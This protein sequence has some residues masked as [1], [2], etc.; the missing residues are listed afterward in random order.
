MQLRP[1]QDAARNAVYTALEQRTDNPCVVL[2]TGAGKTPLMAALVRDTLAWGG[3]IGVVAHV[4]ELLEQTADKL[5]AFDISPM[6]IGI[7]SAGLNSRNTDA[8]CI[9]AG[10]QSVYK[11]ACEFGRFDI[12]LVDEAHL[13]PASGEGMYQTFLADAAVVNPKMRVIG[14][15][16]TPYRLDVGEI[17]APD[18]I[19]NHVCYEASVRD[20]IAQGFLCKLRSK[21]A[22]EASTINVA[23]VA[24]RGGEYVASELEAAADT[25]EAVQGAVDEILS[26]T[27]DRKGTLI[28]CAGVKHAHHVADEITARGEHCEVITG[29][30]PT[31][32]R[33][34]IIAAFK[35]GELRYLANV[36][37]LTTGFDATHIDCVAM[38]R[39]TLSPGLYYQ[40]CGRG[41][42]IHEG[43][44]DC[45]ILDFAGNVREHGPIDAIKPKRPGAASTGDG[46]AAVKEC[47]ACRELIAAGYR[48][49]PQCGEEFP[50]DKPK[51]AKTADTSRIIS[52]DED[53]W[54]DV[55]S[56]M[57]TK[58]PGK[59]INPRDPN[60]PRKPDSVRVDYDVG[61]L[62]PIISEWV[63][64][65][66]EGFART[67]FEKWWG[68][69]THIEPQIDAE[70]V[71][72]IARS[73]AL[74]VPSRIRVQKKAGAK[75]SEITSVEFD[76]P[77][78]PID[79]AEAD[80]AHACRKVM[81]HAVFVEVF[82]ELAL[83]EVNAVDI[84]D[85]LPF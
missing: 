46:E 67:K 62:Q 76:R 19:L 60:S 81:P 80:A 33:A 43:K 47:P 78:P 32:E 26:Y 20:L 54:Y 22:L 4:R 16:A 7:Y 79:E 48:Q 56:V 72:A 14:L 27:Q 52:H 3:R 45:L 75:F 23:G 74:R 15:T 28:F 38:L 73:G 44:E 2:P 13:I 58:W 11:R 53:E 64:P 21:A 37:V 18:H 83:A 57:C 9:I 39:P 61:T 50:D 63:C 68:L 84:E 35:S 1:Y 30:T 42:R 59:Y 12:I 40:M 51:H 77:I 34:E 10:I 31:G 71:A 85:D 49:C 41:L 17:C 69:R 24:K 8:P 29:E 36:Q 65:E 6:D 55:H 70:V 5:S 82:G 66:H 25:D